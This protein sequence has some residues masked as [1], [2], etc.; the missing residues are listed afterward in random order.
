MVRKRLK[1]VENGERD[2]RSR[3]SLARMSVPIENVK[4]HSVRRQFFGSGPFQQYKSGEDIFLSRQVPQ[5]DGDGAF[6]QISRN[7]QNA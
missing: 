1:L 5:Q 2:F 6:Q 3:K 7:P 4:R